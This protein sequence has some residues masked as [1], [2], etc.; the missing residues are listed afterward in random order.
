MSIKKLLISLIIVILIVFILYFYRVPD[1]PTREDHDNTIYAPCDGKVLNID[2]SGDY[3]NIYTFI[4]VFDVHVQFAPVSGFIKHIEEIPGNYSPAFDLS[5]S[6]N[7]YRVKI[8]MET[9]DKKEIIIVL[10]S[11]LLARRISVFPCVG[12]YVEQGTIIS[13]IHLGSGCHTII[14]KSH[15]N[16]INVNKDQ[17]IKA[18]ET[19]LLSMNKTS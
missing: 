13:R 15:V 5:K 19:K 8:I 12:D 4:S 11:G 10:K 9:K 1:R 2:T 6:A 7:N 18:S 17:S 16:A 3:I 14:H